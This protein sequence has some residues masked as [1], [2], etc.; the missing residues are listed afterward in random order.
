MEINSDELIHTFHKL[1]QEQV[2][3]IVSNICEGENLNY[4]E[5]AEKY[6]LVNNNIRRDYKPKKKR[7]VKIPLPQDRCNALASEGDQ[8]K[9]SKK[10]G[11]CYCRRHIKKRSYGTILDKPII[12]KKKSNEIVPNTN[13]KNDEDEELEIEHKGNLITLEDG[14][15]VIFIP[16]T[17][18]CYSHTMRPE[19]LGILSEDN[20]RIIKD[21]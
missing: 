7:D 11:T 1:V 13:T 6:G 2:N 15:E 14:T 9:R 16:T 18:I 21:Y 8:C 5:V 12:D 10:D 19:K 4:V 17:G 20:K 3:N